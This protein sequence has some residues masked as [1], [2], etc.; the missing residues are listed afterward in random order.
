MTGPDA[1][2]DVA[3]A[4]AEWGARPVRILPLRPEA[5]PRAVRTSFRVELPDGTVVKARR[6]ESEV[7]ARQQVEL[8][9]GLPEAFAPVLARFGPILVEAWVD[10]LPLSAVPV[11]EP[12]IRQA[13]TLLAALHAWPRSGGRSLP[14][15]AAVDGLI[16]DILS[17]LQSLAA[18]GILEARTADR[19][20]SILRGSAPGEVPHCLIHTDFCGE[21]IVL[22]ADGR[23]AVID[24][25][26]FRLGPAAI[27]LARSRYRWGWPMLEAG[28]AWRWFGE[29]YEA[30]G[31]V[32][33]SAREGRF[34]RVAAV[35]VSARIRFRAGDPGLAEP[36]GLLRDMAAGFGDEGEARA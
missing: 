34:W 19:L 11:S 8:R 1:F 21:N 35:V 25:E 26:H 33:A 4:V 22:A 3:D 32:A 31:G 18:S 23:L 10:G 9:A 28:D 14:F 7:A 2:V 24:N 20:G 27:D 16:E 29:A 30:A 13:G 36:V 15:P 17:G 6:L 12:L 5:G